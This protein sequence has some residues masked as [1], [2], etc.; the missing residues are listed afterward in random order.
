MSCFYSHVLLTSTVLMLHAIHD[1]F[2]IMCSPNDSSIHHTL[3]AQL[4][5]LTFELHL[6]HNSPKMSHCDVYVYSTYGVQ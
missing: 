6:L 5:T 2:C 1:Y 3:T 4:C